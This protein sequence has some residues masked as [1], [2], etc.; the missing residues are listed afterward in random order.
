MESLTRI[1]CV[2]H[3]LPVKTDRSVDRER[4]LTDEG[5][6]DA[7]RVAECLRE[8]RLEVCLS[9]PYARSVDTV[10]PTA[11]EHGL[12]VRYDEDFRER[13]V[14]DTGGQYG[15][16]LKRRWE[17]FDAAEPEG[18]CLRSV[19]E[20]NMRAFRRMLSECEGKN[21]LFGTHG[22]ALS[23]ILH[24]YDPA[25]GLD[26]FNRIG[27]WMPWVVRMDFDGQE[28]AGREELFHADKRH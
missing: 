26:A 11:R 19:E 16:W 23:V 4:P 3:A 17:D 13:K 5:R 25:W 18:E 12:T 9:S 14:G 1:Y 28:Y 10:L 15:F 7:L 21:V 20:R 27:A 24:H 22:T 6:E 2:R 8:V